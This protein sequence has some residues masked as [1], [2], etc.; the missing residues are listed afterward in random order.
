MKVINKNIVLC[1]QLYSKSVSLEYVDPIMKLSP[2]LCESTVICSCT[3]TSAHACIH[4]CS[5]SGAKI[6]VYFL[7]TG[8]FGAIITVI[9]LK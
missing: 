5:K 2:N 8:D 6:I 3:H 9:Y 4:I 1:Q 7:P